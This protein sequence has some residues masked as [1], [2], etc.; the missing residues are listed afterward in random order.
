MPAEVTGRAEVHKITVATSS[1]ILRGPPPS[2][3][4]GNDLEAIV[5]CK[6]DFNYGTHMRKLHI[7]TI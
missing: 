4:K 2:K 6:S 3:K 1:H 7:F 5:M